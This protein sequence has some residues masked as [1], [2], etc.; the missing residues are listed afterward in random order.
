[1]MGESTSPALFAVQTCHVDCRQRVFFRQGGVSTAPSER[2]KAALGDDV[3]H[4][5]VS[6]KSG[7]LQYPP[8]KSSAAPRPRSHT[9]LSSEQGRVTGAWWPP[10]S[11]KPLSTRTAGEVGSI[12]TLS[13]LRR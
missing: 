3:K 12:P 2:L 7:K 1:M 8:R 5:R 11:S 4:I 13:E 9:L 6:T 10:R